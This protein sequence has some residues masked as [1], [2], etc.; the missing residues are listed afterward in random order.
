[1]EITEAHDGYAR[2]VMDCAG[3]NNPCG[4]AR[5]GAIFALA[6]QAFGIAANCGSVIRFA[7]SIH[8]HYISPAT[9]S[10]VAVAHRVA[11][12]GWYSLFRVMIYEEERTIAEFDGVT[13]QVNTP[14]P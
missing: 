2:V 4:V 8:I 14:H 5:G 10:L 11:E 6:D 9:G 1:M 12:N 13:I 7:V 3:K